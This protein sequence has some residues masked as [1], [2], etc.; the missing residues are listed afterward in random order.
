MDTQQ[1]VT[2]KTGIKK[3]GRPVSSELPKVKDPNINLR[4][5]LNDMLLMEKQNLSGYQAGINEMI[6]DDLRQILIDNRNRVQGLQIRF[7]EEMFNLGEYQAD[8]ASPAHIKD[9]VNIFSGY[10]NQLLLGH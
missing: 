7:F 8:L 4:D 3:I 10:K 5:R 6:N 2:T 9:S 1:L